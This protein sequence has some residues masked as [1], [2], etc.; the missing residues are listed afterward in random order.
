MESLN[1]FIKDKPIETL[2]IA[3]TVICAPGILVGLFD[4]GKEVGHTLATIFK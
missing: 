4:V 1:E 3:L 2:F